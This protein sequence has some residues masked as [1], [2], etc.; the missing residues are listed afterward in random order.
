L[1]GF[2]TGPSDPEAN[3]MS[4][5]PRRKDNSRTFMHI[6]GIEFQFF[7]NSLLNKTTMSQV[8]SIFKYSEKRKM[9][10]AQISTDLFNSVKNFEGFFFPMTTLKT[11][12]LVEAISGANAL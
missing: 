4:T 9:T 12:R 3:A 2:E 10:A 5:A 11:Y 1:A 7:H 8:Q 6:F